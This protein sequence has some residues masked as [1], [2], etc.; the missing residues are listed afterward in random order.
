MTAGQVENIGANRQ[1]FVDDHWID[2]SAGV[3][4]VLHEPVAENIAL[5]AEHPWD[6]IF[7][8][9]HLVLG[10]GSRWRMYYLCSKKGDED[11]PPGG[12]QYC[13]YAESDDGIEWTKPELGVVEL[14]GSKRNNLVYAG[15]HTEVAPFLDANPDAAESERYKAFAVSDRSIPGAR[16]LVPLASPDGLSWRQMSDKP[17][18]VDGPFDSHNL[19]FW[20]TRVGKYVVYSRGV[21]NPDGTVRYSAT[22]GWFAVVGE[23]EKATGA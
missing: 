8:A 12:W 10:D 23:G 17:V 21:G 13:A 7:S 16:G 6:Q 20:D 9:Y 19:P 4:R 11:G 3:E 5:E 18:M 15:P 1:L 14:D 22:K 2:S